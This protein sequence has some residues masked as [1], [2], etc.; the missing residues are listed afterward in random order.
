MKLG[1]AIKIQKA[2]KVERKLS[3]LHTNAAAELMRL[4]DT[5]DHK[6]QTGQPCITKQSKGWS[7]GYRQCAI[8]KQ[9]YEELVTQ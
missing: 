5:C 4:K 7:D 6:D 3:Q 2:I 8:C 9:V 1:D